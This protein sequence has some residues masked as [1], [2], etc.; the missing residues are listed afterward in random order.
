[1]SRTAIFSKIVGANHGHRM[2]RLMTSDF[3][4]YRGGV[5]IAEIARNRVLP[6]VTT[7]D[8]KFDVPNN[9]V[10]DGSSVVSLVGSSPGS[11]V[12]ILNQSANGTTD[13][14]RV[15]VRTT[16]LPGGHLRYRI[17]GY[18]KVAP[19]PAVGNS[20]EDFEILRIVDFQ[21]TERLRSL[22]QSGKR[23]ALLIEHPDAEKLV[24]TGIFN[25]GSWQL[26]TGPMGPRI[27]INP[28]WEWVVIVGILAAAGVAIVFIL[29]LEAMILLGI[30]HGY[31]I[32]IG[33]LS[34][35]QVSVF[36]ATLD[37]NFPTLA[38]ELIPPED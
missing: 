3:R 17:R 24:Q 32:N 25:P 14:A 15:K 22:M 13:E 21:S 7:R 4:G 10:Y 31:R 11:A 35:G 34:L 6:D 26:S 30:L 38:L 27:T 16:V 1:M 37:I 12:E 28:T 29:A 5:D 33:E 19:S 2:A 8:F 20:E 9:L 23:I 36:G 18:G